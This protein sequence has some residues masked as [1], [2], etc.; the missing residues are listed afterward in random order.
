MIK[1]TSII[2]FIFFSISILTV[3]IIGCDDQ[4][5]KPMMDMIAPTD[6]PI[7]TPIQRAREAMERVN[8]RRTES[9]Q[10]AEATE[11]YMI[12]FNDSELILIEELGFR[13]AFWI[14]LVDIYK[15]EKSENPLVVDGF[16][17]LED[18]FA[19]RLAENTLGLH[20]FEYIRTFDPLIIEYLRLSYV[21]PTADEAELLSKFRKLIVEDKVKVIFP[22]DF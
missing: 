9:L 2:I 3:F 11:D 16:T 8:H 20:Y 19:E 12:V 7:Q 15:E 4:M 18:N 5:T 13:R 21:Y 17:A 22:E 1:F 10:K 14:E 6:P